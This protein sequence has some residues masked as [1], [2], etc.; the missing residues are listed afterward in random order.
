MDLEML[1]RIQFGL[2]I[3][4]HYLFPPL[5]IGLGVFLVIM[6]G[7]YLK[8]GKVIY[9]NM[10]R[11]WVK[12]FGLIFALGVATG[13]VME[14]QFGTN[15]ATYS[16]YVGDVFGSA[17][18]A[19]GIFAFFLESGFLAILLFG[20]DKVSKT[21]HFVATILVAFGAHFSAIWIVV[22]N[23]WQQTPTGHHIVGTGLDARA[24]ILDFWQVVF[25]PSFID[26]ISHVY[27]GCW[28][29]AAFMVLSVGAF[30]LLRGKHQEFAKKSMKIAVIVAV[31]SSLGQLATGHMSADTVAETQPAKLAAF[32]GHYEASAPAGLYLFGWVDDER[33]EVTGLQIPGMLSWLVHF[34]ASEPVTG[35]NAFDP[36][37]RPPVNPVFQSYHAMV[38][39][40]MLLIALALLAGLAWWR[41]WLFKMRW[42]LW[43]LVFSVLL[44]QLANQLGWFSAEVGRQPWIVYGLLRTQDA[45]S[46]SVDAGEVIISLVLFSLI[47]LLLGALFIYLLN[48]KIQHGPEVEA[49]S[50]GG[51]M[52]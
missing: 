45:L 3:G 33:Q 19:E 1:S 8:T 32:E 10:T 30:Y 11:F 17:L 38:S 5:S 7:A 26:R 47:Y 42:F 12:I 25:N 36:E 23:S 31:L 14:F 21:T 41:G 49:Q 34:D 35:L 9:H 15:W 44:P 22:A 40:G 43:V 29:A 46:K 39:I 4:F 2:T 51:H 27:M 52:A 48:E 50:T 16:R 37:D 13:I 28:Q 20:W 6:E 18:A 24:E